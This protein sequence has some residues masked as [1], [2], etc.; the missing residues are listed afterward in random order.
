MLISGLTPLTVALAGKVNIITW[1][2]GVSYEKLNVFHR[3]GGYAICVLGTI[4][5]VSQ[6]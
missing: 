3:Y 1:M 4:H 5:T 6:S 2:T